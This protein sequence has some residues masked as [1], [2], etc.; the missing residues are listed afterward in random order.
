MC[1]SMHAPSAVHISAASLHCRSAGPPATS[2]MRR[3]CL[4]TCCTSCMK[5]RDDTERCYP[6]PPFEVVV[7]EMDG[8]MQPSYMVYENY[9]AYPFVVQIS[10]PD[11]RRRVD[12][13]VES[14]I[15]GCGTASIAETFIRL[16]SNFPSSGWPL[17]SSW[18]FLYH[19][20][21]LLRCQAAVRLAGSGIMS[22]SCQQCQILI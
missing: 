3:I 7:C 12:P 13:L 20:A 16:H 14:V 19:A 1:R 22:G 21:A 6:G 4:I 8:V 18:N 5:D 15:G 9:V 17:W 10:Q 11:H 2:R